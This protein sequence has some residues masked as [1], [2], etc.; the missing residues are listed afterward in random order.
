MAVDEYNLDGDSPREACGVVGIYAPGQAV[1]HM[2]YLSLY[3]LQHRGQESALS[4]IH[5]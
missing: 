3:A 1:A 2:N 4:L 5:I